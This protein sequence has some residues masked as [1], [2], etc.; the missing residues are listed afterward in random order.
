MADFEFNGL[1]EF[2]SQLSDVAESYGNTCEKHLRTIGNKYRKEIIARTPDS[3]STWEYDESKT[4]QENNNRKRRF[5]KLKLKKGWKFEVKGYHGSDLKL[6]LWT[7]N[8]K[9][10]LL[11][12][13]HKIISHGKNA[14][15]VQGKFFFKKASETMEN[16]VIPEELEKLMKDITK[17]MG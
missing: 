7:S 1:E 5:A 3:G 8:K 12:R 4:K 16:E 10:H 2:I 14:G 17:K 13:G 11:E 9:F 15:F 6:E